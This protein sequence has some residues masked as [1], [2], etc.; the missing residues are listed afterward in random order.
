MTSRQYIKRVWRVP[1][2][3]GAPAYLAA[4]VVKALVKHGWPA[5]SKPLAWSDEG[6]YI[7]HVDGRSYEQLPDDMAAAVAV[8]VRIVARTHRLDVTENFGSVILNR[9][10]IVTDGGFFREVKHDPSGQS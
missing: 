2:D 10:Y 6:F 1:K 8:A 5:Q 3:R 7:A 9:R 4:L